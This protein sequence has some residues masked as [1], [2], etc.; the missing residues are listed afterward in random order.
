M[1]KLKTPP[2]RPPKNPK[3]VRNT[4]ILVKMTK[5]EH[6]TIHAL[7]KQLGRRAGEIMRT[8]A[9]DKARRLG[10]TAETDTL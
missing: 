6:A 8:A 4:A 7:A 5:E 10:I 1:S 2:A 9:L 3:T